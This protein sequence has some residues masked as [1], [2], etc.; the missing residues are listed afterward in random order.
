MFTARVSTLR[1]MSS[2]NAARDGV[3]GSRAIA[4]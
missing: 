4:R 2:R 3:G 1:P